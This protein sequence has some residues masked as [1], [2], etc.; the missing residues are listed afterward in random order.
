MPYV[1]SDN[2]IAQAITEIN[3]IKNHL[4]QSKKTK[5]HMFDKFNTASNMLKCKG[6]AIG[7]RNPQEDFGFY[8]SNDNVLSKYLLGETGDSSYNDIFNLTTFVLE[9]E[10]TSEQFASALSALFV[11]DKNIKCYP[12]KLRLVIKDKGELYEDHMFINFVQFFDDDGTF[13]HSYYTN[14][15]DDIKNVL[16]L[17]KMSAQIKSKLL[18]D[19]QEC[20]L[21]EFVGLNYFDTDFDFDKNYTIFQSLTDVGGI[22]FNYPAYEWDFQN[23]E[24]EK[25]ANLE[26]YISKKELKQHMQNYLI[27]QS[28][29]A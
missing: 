25:C 6:K 24:Y 2:N 18:T 20:V 1:E 28:T 14:L 5:E 11:G 22:G 7:S 17:E 8:D 27:N 9:H 26:N 4:N 10:G 12:V 21:I 19:T 23:A 13:L 3:A 15:F 29:F 16:T